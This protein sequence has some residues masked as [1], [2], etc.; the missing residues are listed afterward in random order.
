M[1]VLYRKL[2]AE[3]AGTALLL[4]TV[5][6]SG[7]MGERLAGGNA[8]ITLLANSLATGTILYALIAAMGNIS[9][10]HFNPVVTL[11]EAWLGK[12]PWRQ[13]GWYVL[14]QV[15]AALAGVAAAHWMFGLPAFIASTHMRSGL[16]Q[17]FSEA[18]ATFGLITVILNCARWKPETV[19]AAVA[20]YITAAY[21]FTASTSFANPAVTLAR[22]LT[23]TFSGIRPADAP[24][25]IAAQFAGTA[26]A[27]GLHRWLAA[28]RSP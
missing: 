3:F 28:E 25:F 1:S 2:A 17:M 6:G 20:A 19:P 15:V 8:A 7:I 13:A 21:W 5:V 26:I 14:I 11:A 23:D 18:V 10:A 4:A 9:G 16:S 22:S 27:A 12:L 24:A